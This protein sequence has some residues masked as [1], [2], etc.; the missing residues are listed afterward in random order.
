MRAFPVPHRPITRRLP[1]A[2]EWSALLAGLAAIILL[3][4]VYAAWIG[5]TNPTI[6]ALSFLFV[7]LLVAAV[8]TRWVAISKSLAAF[9]FFNYF[10]LPPVGTWT[11][12]DPE[13]WVALFTLLTVSIVASHLSVQVR[14]RANE[15]TARRDELAFH[16]EMRARDLIARGVEPSEARRKARERLGNLADVKRTCLDEGRKRDR[17]MRVMQWIDE[18][19][20]D[21]KFALRQLARAPAFAL[22][23][24]AT[25]ALG[26]GANSAIFALVDAT[27]LRPLP[28]PE[29]DRLM[30]VW[31]ETE[32]SQRSGAS[33]LNVADW[34]ERSRTFERLAGFV[35]SVGGMV[36][37]GADGTAETV[38]R[39]WVRAGVFDVLGIKAVRAAR[40]SPTTSGDARTSSC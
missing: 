23:A 38:P 11:I 39:Q 35:P 40:F 8:S 21:T 1:R 32:G 6:V 16:L 24:M 26:I 20:D 25:L 22:V 9:F 13:N 37:A 28:F 7:V 15:A 30:L 27:L 14:Q 2:V 12:T 34:N 18:L 10:F 19:G 31:E 33:P 29:P 17:T 4:G 5:V 3:T 36:M